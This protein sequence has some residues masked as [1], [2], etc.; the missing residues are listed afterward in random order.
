MAKIP[1]INRNKVEK[2]PERVE[3]YPKQPPATYLT[4]RFFPLMIFT[5]LTGVFTL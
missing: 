1:P 2:N 5:P 4:I 3:D